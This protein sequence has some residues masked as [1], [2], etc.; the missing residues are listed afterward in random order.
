MANVGQD[1][2]RIAE[3]IEQS[4]ERNI[5]RRRANDV[6]FICQNHMFSI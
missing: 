3:Q 4:Q 1:L 6:S 2:R 5:I